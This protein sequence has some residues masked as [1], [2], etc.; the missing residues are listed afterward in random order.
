LLNI[1][2][3]FLFIALESLFLV[4]KLV[5]GYILFICKHLSINILQKAS[6]KF[7]INNTPSRHDQNMKKRFLD[8]LKSIIA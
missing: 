8:A 1:N 4:K 3:K 6:V 7:L 5:S 2:F